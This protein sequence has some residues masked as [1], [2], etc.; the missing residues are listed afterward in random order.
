MGRPK[1]LLRFQGRTF[2]EHILDAIG[3]S[4][5]GETIV[6]LG[7]HR[8]E[9]GETLG[10]AMVA[11]NPT[12][13]RGM[14]TSIQTGVRALL[15]R[16]DGAMLFL[17]DHPM[18]DPRTIDLL[19][20]ALKPSRIV[21][22]T[23]CGRRGHPVLFAA[24]I[25][26]EILDLAESEGANTVV[27]KDPGRVIEIPVSSPGVLTDIDTPQQFLDLLDDKT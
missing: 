21:L 14:V 17:V 22:P 2:I 15:G 5:I 13:E 4:S 10:D 26:P 24:D 19:A 8:A 25:L 23:F 12:Y 11:F 18:I 3:H 1:A 7:H 16:V 27:R 9:I 20:A 6:V